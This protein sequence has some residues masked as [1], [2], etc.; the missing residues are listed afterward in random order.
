MIQKAFQIV[1]HQRNR[2]QWT[3][4]STEVLALVLFYKEQ[5]VS[6]P[7]DRAVLFHVEYLTK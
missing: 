5:S 1:Q 4:I 7:S 2:H 6:V 3:L